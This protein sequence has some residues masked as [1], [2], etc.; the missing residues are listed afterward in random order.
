MKKMFDYLRGSN[1]RIRIIV[2]S[3]FLWVS[4]LFYR[5]W[6]R[7]MDGDDFQL[8]HSA[9]TTSWKEYLVPFGG[10]LNFYQRGMTELGF[11]SSFSHYFM[12]AYVISLSIWTISTVTIQTSFEK[13]FDSFWC[14]FAAACCF[15]LM[16][17][18]N[19]MQVG[20]IIS[21]REPLV[22]ALVVVISTKNYPKKRVGFLLLTVFSLFVALSSPIAW[23]LS[24]VLIGSRFL[25][26]KKLLP[27]EFWLVTTLLIGG[28]V[29][30]FTY[31]TIKTDKYTSGHRV[32]TLSFKQILYGFEWMAH[33]FLPSKL[34]GSFISGFDNQLSVLRYVLFL[35]I[36]AAIFI[37][38]FRLP[39]LRVSNRNIEMWFRMIASGFGLTFTAFS[40][41]RI[42]NYHYILLGCFTLYAF[43]A[44]GFIELFKVKDNLLRIEKLILVSVLF[45]LV[46]G[47]LTAIRPAHGDRYFWNRA[48]FTNG[49]VRWRYNVESSRL[50]CAYLDLDAVTIPFSNPDYPFLF[51]CSELGKRVKL[52]RIDW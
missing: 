5:S 20:S 34:R 11:I 18:T 22:V 40:L 51:P 38:F 27:V 30:L 25:F 36:L 28:F 21:G 15:V 48:E 17:V 43:F 10:Y 45:V 4:I 46:L 12:V 35:L 31:A 44:L 2:A 29:Q 42:S 39:S 16:P 32:K 6:G 1:S 3:I 24:F 49:F 7:G 19:L 13:Y 50:A 52:T 33:S 8:L 47:A 14:G 41:S 26:R 23:L 9:V 37:I